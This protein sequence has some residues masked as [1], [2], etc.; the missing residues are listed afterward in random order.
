MNRKEVVVSAALPDLRMHDDGAVE[1]CHFVGAGR[2]AGNDEFIM[3]HD[4]I[5]PPCV[6]DIAL[7]QYAEWTVVPESV[8]SAVDFGRLKQKASAFAQGNELLHLHG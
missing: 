2:T 8:E 4:P 1:S 5:V 3:G 7:A 6:F